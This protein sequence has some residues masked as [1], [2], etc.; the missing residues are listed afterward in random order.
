M[1][2]AMPPFGGP[3]RSTSGM[4]DKDRPSHDE[5]LR[6]KARALVAAASLPLPLPRR[7][8]GGPGVGAPCTLCGMAVDG[9]EVDIEIDLAGRDGAGESCHFHVRCLAALEHELREP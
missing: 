2:Q 1:D 5:V 7:R 3:E 6:A 4:V 8:W 9:H